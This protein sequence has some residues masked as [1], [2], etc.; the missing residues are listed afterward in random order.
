MSTLGKR[1]LLA[2]VPTATAALIAWGWLSYQPAPSVAAPAAAPISRVSSENGLTIVTL[3]EA[4]QKRSGIATDALTA[5][6]RQLNETAYGSVLDLQPLI[7]LQTRYRAAAADVASAQAALDASSQEAE[8]N[9]VLFKDHINISQKAMQAAQA[10]WSA[11]Q[12]KL[13]SAEANLEGVHASARQQF[14]PP[15]ASLIAGKD[16]AFAAL[17]DGQDMMLRIV[18]P[19]DGSTSAPDRITF[20]G[21]TRGQ[22]TGRLVSASPQS[23]PI[24]EGP[25][26]LYRA[27]ASL[28]VGSKVIARLPVSQQPAPG[29]VIPRTAVLWFGGLP[30]AYVQQGKERFVRRLVND[31]SPYDGGYFV[32][33]GFEAGERVVTRGAQLLLSEE[34]RPPV[35]A[36]AACKDPECDD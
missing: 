4:T 8:R 9:R 34:Q 12:A 10:A 19:I 22:L 32:D 33:A 18:L 13:Q 5:T 21:G 35:T 1:L 17:L 26:F 14:G 25:T 24:A 7:D 11:D 31:Q 3:D 30:W 16:T 28:P 2:L 6:K 20:D 36:A 15:L 27:P 29:V 23:D